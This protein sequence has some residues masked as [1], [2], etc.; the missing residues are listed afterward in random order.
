MPDSDQSF[1][2][3]ARLRPE[4]EE[5]LTGG[6]TLSASRRGERDIDSVRSPSGPCA[7]SRAWP[8]GRPAAFLL[9][10]VMFFFPF[11]FYVFFQNFFKTTPI[12]LKPVSKV[13]KNSQQHFKTVGNH[14]S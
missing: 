6:V 10:F 4:L 5:D 2:V 1:R 11:L 13:L 14:F 8:N 12:E 9:F 3:Y 7:V